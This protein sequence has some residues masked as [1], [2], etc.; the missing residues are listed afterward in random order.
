MA[1]HAEGRQT[2]PA[3]ASSPACPKAHTSPP[4]RI[5]SS[6]ETKGTVPK[7]SCAHVASRRAVSIPQP[8]TQWRCREARTAAGGA[9]GASARCS[10]GCDAAASHARSSRA[11]LPRLQAYRSNLAR[12]PPRDCP[13]A[14]SPCAE[15]LSPAVELSRISSMPLA[16][17]TQASGTNAPPEYRRRFLCHFSSR[18]SSPVSSP[19]AFP[20][21]VR[22]RQRLI[23]S[24][25]S[26]VAGKW[27]GDC[28][29][30][31]GPWWT[32]EQL[33]HTC[34]SLPLSTSFREY[35]PP[36]R[37][38]A[39]WQHLFA[40]LAGRLSPVLG[41]SANTSSTPHAPLMVVASTT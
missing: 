9:R 8:C 41:S 20:S 27:L 7:R 10:C 15:S 39:N 22:C 36:A 32:A 12:A 17:S 2:S 29:A 28:C 37:L 35:V 19:P 24:L 6:S 11:C 34:G 30:L 16:S 5:T 31:P 23:S 38:M 33:L 13:S 1:R 4:P 40:A 26:T 18:S 3:C 21:I 14:S 25:S